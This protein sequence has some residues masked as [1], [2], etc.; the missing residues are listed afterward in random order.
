VR[1]V[2]E[3]RN[4]FSSSI[5]AI[6][7]A[8]CAAA[9]AT[10]S[11]SESGN[12]GLP[13]SVPQATEPWGPRQSDYVT[14]FNFSYSYADLDGIL[15]ERVAGR[16]GVGHFLTDEHE[17]GLDFATV[18]DGLEGGGS[19]SRY[20]LGP[21][22]HYNLPL[23]ARTSIYAGPHLGLEYSDGSGVSSQIDFAYGVQAGIRHWLSPKVSFNLETRY[24]HT[25][26][27]SSGLNN[28]DELGLFLGFDVVLSP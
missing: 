15:S 20:F 27:G 22:Y 25:E 5:L 24:T 16:L 8:G 7:A 10:L 23:T 4:R 13:R 18:Y 26:L 14:S 6:V 19:S 9:P 2:H 1:C 17:V 3:G 11:F 28:R 12:T 21:F